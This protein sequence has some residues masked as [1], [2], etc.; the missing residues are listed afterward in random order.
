LKGGRFAVEVAWSDFSGGRGAGRAVP[1]T[2]DTGS[3]WFFDD[4]NLELVVK[5]LDGRGLNG[6][7]WVFYG[8]LS[9]VEYTLTVTD[10]QTG[11]VA[12]YAN[13]SGRLASRGDTAAL[14]G[15]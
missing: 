11:R 15:S 10:T 14:P 9:S 3:F 1:L 6:K 4:A 7:F 12:T 8:A 13:P 2:A 5:V